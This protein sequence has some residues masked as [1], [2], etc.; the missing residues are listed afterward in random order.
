VQQQAQ[1]HV[2]QMEDML[3]ASVSNMKRM[4]IL[5]AAF[6]GAALIGVIGLLFFR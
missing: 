6:M 1:A 2:D 5:A 4:F 3:E